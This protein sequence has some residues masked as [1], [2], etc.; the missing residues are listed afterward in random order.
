MSRLG[1]GLGLTSRRRGVGGGGGSSTLYVMLGVGQSNIMGQG[2]HLALLNSSPDGTLSPHP[3]MLSG[4]IRAGTT[5]SGSPVS[6]IEST[7][8]GTSA[9]GG[10]ET[11]ASGFARRLARLVPGI[12]L[13]VSIAGLGGTAYSGLKKGTGPYTQQIGHANRWKAI[14]DSNG[15]T[16]VFLGAANL[17]GE[18]D[19]EARNTS[20]GANVLE[21]WTDLNTDLKAIS[22]QSQDIVFYISPQMHYTAQAGEAAVAASASAPQVFNT[23]TSH[24]DKFCVIGN[25]RVYP[26]AYDGAIHMGA[27]GQ[28]WTGETV[29]AACYR[30][31]FLNTTHLG[32]MPQSATI[33]GATITVNFSVPVPPIA[34]DFRY[35]MRNADRICGVSYFDDTSPPSVTGVSVASATSLSVT[36]SGT[37]TTSTPSS[38]KIRFGWDSGGGNAILNSFNRTNIRDSE[39]TVGL[40]GQPLFNWCPVAQLTVT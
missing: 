29:G 39:P 40:Y 7:T 1:I 11:F 4:G 21:W 20:Y 24:P 38:R 16:L 27:P 2:T 10:Y 6:L 15:W 14:A 25:R 35:V 12:R 19:H 34:L 13:G 33:A 26:I 8:S 32:L 31:Q 22:G 37:P 17:H 23:A 28:A 30:R 9:E 18:Q 3:L 36:L 5:V